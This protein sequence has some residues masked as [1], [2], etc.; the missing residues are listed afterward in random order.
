M[1]RA[2]RDF[3]T[4]N[5]TCGRPTYR[6]FTLIEVI[7]VIVLITV[8]TAAIVPSLTGSSSAGNDLGAQHAVTETIA[9]EVRAYQAGGAFEDPSSPAG[10]SALEQQA[11]SLSFVVGSSA[12]TGPSVVSVSLSGSDLWLAA[13][14]SNGDCWFAL[15]NFSATS[16]SPTVLYG[17]ENAGG[18]SPCS[19]VTASSLTPSSTDPELG[20]AWSNPI[21]VS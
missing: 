17:T 10:L 1:Y 18:T 21:P 3:L 16:G 12:S 7:V 15:R 6:G 8:L 19:S 11:P 20:S 9:A 4:P 14:A 5:T 13:A 2:R